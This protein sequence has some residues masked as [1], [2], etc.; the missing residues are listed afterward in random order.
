[1]LFRLVA[2]LALGVLLLTARPAGAAQPQDSETPYPGITYTLWLD[3][4]LPARIHVVAVDLTSASIDLI[5]TAQNQRGQT[6]TAFAGAVGAVV[7][8]NGDYFAPNGYT[9]DGLARGNSQ[10]WEGTAD[11]DL[12]GFV[13]F[14]HDAARTQVTLS[15]PSQV[16]ES[17]PDQTVGAVAGRPLL[18]QGG[19][20]VPSFAC[21][22]L[23]A[24][25][26]DPA[27]R[28]AVALSADGNTLYLVVVDGWQSSSAG[29]TARQLADFLAGDLGADKA[30]MLDGGSAS[31][32]FFNGDLKS[33][34]SDGVERPVA[35]H[36]AVRYGAQPNGTI[37]GGVFERSVG[38]TK[39]SGVTVTLDD[40]TSKSYDPTVND[41][42]FSVAPRWVCVTAT[43]TGYHPNTGCR[44]VQ[45]TQIVYDSI[46]LYP[47]SDFVDGGPGGT[48]DASTDLPDAG[49][50]VDPA[51]AAPGHG[52]AD[53]GDPG[54][55]V[56]GGCGCRTGGH[57]SG[58]PA[59]L[60]SLFLFCVVL[61]RL[62]FRRLRQ[63]PR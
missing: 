20:A 63:G 44:Q 55:G 12:S 53:A 31:A 13:G 34:P 11:D 25:P 39:L 21:E 38:G 4:T 14:Y 45:S 47:N 51:D 46:A 28:T 52:A 1:M 2:A 60:G 41:W 8:I 35:N 37:R 9:P 54:G 61:T 42:Q 36:L 19:A 17:V 58:G 6:P 30:L 59:A 40:G 22:D 62:R 16:V 26:C 7:A 15:A 57:G 3:S 18:V 10:T 50:P 32:L 5:A 43:K 48:P 56:G 23:V 49:G 29:M 33:A 27:P 24:M